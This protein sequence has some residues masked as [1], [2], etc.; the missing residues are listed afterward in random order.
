[1]HHIIR[2]SKYAQIGNIDSL[3]ALFGHNQV[4][5][6]QFDLKFKKKSI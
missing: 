6:L 4:H 5:T 3:I 1:M 2:R